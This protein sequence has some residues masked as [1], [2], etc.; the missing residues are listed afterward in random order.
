MMVKSRKDIMLINYIILK[1]LNP[2]YKSPILTYS[3]N[4][5]LVSINI[6]KNIDLLLSYRLFSHCLF[7]IQHTFCLYQSLT[8]G[9]FIIL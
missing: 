1:V 6:S 8:F 5:I 4:V 3:I 2:N 9:L 7:F